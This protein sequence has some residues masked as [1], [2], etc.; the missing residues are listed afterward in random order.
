[1]FPKYW[2]VGFHSNVQPLHMLYFKY[3]HSI[4][5]I[6]F[7]YCCLKILKLDN[8]EIMTTYLA[9]REFHH[10]M[11][12]PVSN[13]MTSI[14]QQLYISSPIY[15]Y[16]AAISDKSFCLT[17]DCCFCELVVKNL[18]QHVCLAQS[19]VHSLPLISSMLLTWIDMKYLL[20]DVKNIQ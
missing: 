19:R 20:L 2:E 3:E 16:S 8:N 10:E 18:A 9:I 14:W 11:T 7:I 6:T 13:S 15:T 17:A 4:S 1:M 12:T 5:S